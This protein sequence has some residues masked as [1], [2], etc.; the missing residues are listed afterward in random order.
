MSISKNIARTVSAFA[1]SLCSACMLEANADAPQRALD[2]M[3]ALPARE[4]EPA[5]PAAPAD[6][7]KKGAQS[8]VERLLDLMHQATVTGSTLTSG[9]S[10]K[11]SS[12]SA[13]A[14][15]LDVMAHVPAAPKVSARELA[16]NRGFIWPV[17]GLIYSAFQ[18]TRSGGRV[19]GAVDICAPNGTPVAA[20][21]DGIVSVVADGGKS[22]RG[23]GKIV[24]IDHGSGVHTVY[25]HLSSYAVK[26][27]Q[28]VARGEI[29]GAV[30]KTGTAT[31]YLLHYEVRLDG[32][33]IDPLLC[34]EDRPG[35]VKMVNYHSGKR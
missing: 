23:Y 18:A 8:N 13:V 20:A 26:M 31:N 27:G 7:A 1:L 33:K 35:V 15:A 3:A 9:A 6:T 5:A 34:M 32:K 17:D 2:L 10:S 29:I 11:T 4:S 28:K 14:R 24:I 19:H 22:Y 12:S 21:H 25:A 16:K 30:G